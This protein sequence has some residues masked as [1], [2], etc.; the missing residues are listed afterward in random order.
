M[1]TSAMKVK[2]N[3]KKN[4]PKKKKL[5]KYSESFNLDSSLVK[6]F[7]GK[8]ETLPSLL[9]GYKASLNFDI[10]KDQESVILT[11]S[12]KHRNQVQVIVCKLVERYN[13][14]VLI[15]NNLI[16]HINKNN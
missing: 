16:T 3:R 4:T 12:A 2:K 8:K 1:H 6:S 13:K 14:I 10:S 11:V 15:T 7:I 5:V 9:A